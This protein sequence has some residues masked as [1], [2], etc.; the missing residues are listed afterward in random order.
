[1]THLR[2]WASMLILTIGAVFLIASPKASIKT[3]EVIQILDN[4]YSNAEA[5]SLDPIEAKSERV[6][7]KIAEAIYKRFKCQEDVAL[8]AVQYAEEFAHKDFPR[9]QD[10]L[11][12]IAIESSFNPSAEF[13]GSKGV[14]QVLVKTHRARITGEFDLREQI[15]VG[16]SILREYYEITG[17]K[18]A[19][20]MSYNVGIGSYK[21]GAR[22]EKYFGKY[23]K[24]LLW[25][26][27][28]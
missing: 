18:Q 8:L 1:M 25:V 10:L 23:R 27:S 12:I 16:A 21:R 22:P 24:E 15:R 13:K 7:A 28:L 20:V 5:I 19:A 3:I 26:S 6:N 9:K 11:A 14:M 4:V 2:R 17:G